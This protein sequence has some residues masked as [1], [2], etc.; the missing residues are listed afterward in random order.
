[1]SDTY[2]VIGANGAQGGAV[3]RRLARAGHRVRGLTRTASSGAGARPGPA[4]IEWVAGA[5]EDRA[6]LRAAF[7]GVTHAS[8]TLP[9][10]Y[11]PARVAAYTDNLIEAAT[12]ANLRRLVFNTTSRLPARP[13]TANAFE[14]RRTA[15][16]ALLASGIPAVVL[17]PPVY[18]DNLCGPWVAPALM[19]D[20]VLGYPIPADSPVGWLAHDD[21]GAITAA[22][23]Q[24]D[25]LVGTAI[26]VGG[27]EVLTGPELARVFGEVLDR[28]VS[29][30]AVPPDAFEAGLIP[31]F[32]PEM[33]VEV[34]ATYHWLATP[35]GAQLFGGDPGKVEETFGVRLTPLRDW[36]AAQPWQELAGA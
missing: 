10:V 27:S 2:L 22:A 19:A 4:G 9:L 14:T 21:L 12:A 25:E 30:A 26:D 3:A 16:E 11:D 36:I 35:D 8:V 17:R 29:Y 1:M 34:A 23:F 28:P 6:A 13:T 7:D 5:L 20:G 33:A 32:G 24:R 31:V 15:A 18:L